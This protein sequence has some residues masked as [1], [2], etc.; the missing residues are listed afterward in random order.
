M[1][2][3]ASAARGLAFIHLAS[4]RRGSGMPKLAHGNI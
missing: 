3:A 1:P 4:Q 2:I